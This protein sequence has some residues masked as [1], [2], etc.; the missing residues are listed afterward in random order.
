MN[1]DQANNAITS[2]NSTDVVDGGAGVDTLELTASANNNTQLVGVVKNVEI[3]KIAGSDNINYSLTDADVVA[4]AEA[5]G[6]VA[7]AQ[8]A[9]N[10][11]VAADA[12][13]E[14]ANQAL[15]TAIADETAAAAVNDAVQVIQLVD[16]LNNEEAI[17]AALIAATGAAVLSGSSADNAV[18]QAV[19]N[20]AGQAGAT[21]ATVQAAAQLAYAG[22]A[23]ALANAEEAQQTADAEA[24]A[25]VGALLADLNSAKETLSQLEAA[26]G[27]ASIDASFFQGSTDLILDGK[28]TAVTDVT[29]QTVTFNA[30]A[31]V[32]NSVSYA[33]EVT[34]GKIVLEGVRGTLNL[35]GDDLDT[36]TVEGAV[37]AN[38]KNAG[39]LTLDLADSVKTLNLNL[40]TDAVVKLSGEGELTSITSTGSKNLTLEGLADTVASVTTADGN[41]ELT[42]STALNGNTVK[43]ATV[44]TGAGNDKVAVNVASNT[45]GNKVTVNTG[46]GDDEITVVGRGN[47]ALAISAGAGNDVVNL[48]G[49]TLTTADL[50]DGGEGVDTVVITGKDARTADDY[51]ILNNLLTGFETIKFVSDEG[52]SAALDASKLAARYTTLE[53]AQDGEVVKVGAQQLIAH[54]DLTATAAG[55]VAGVDGTE[56]VYAGTLNIVGQENNWFSDNITAYASAINLTVDASTGNSSYDLRGDVKSAT[57]TLV[58][59]L[60][61]DGDAFVGA[62][63]FELE[64][65]ADEYDDLAELTTLTLSGNG[66]ATV[67]NGD[68]TKL[69]T[70]N[71]SGLNSTNADG[72]IAAGLTY[73]SDNELAETITLGAG[74]DVITLNASTVDATDAIIGFSVVKTAGAFDAAK[75]DSLEI[76]GVNG[77]QLTKF[78]TTQTSLELALLD[79]AR[80]V[81]GVAKDTLAFQFGSDTYVFKD[82]GEAIVGNDV[83]DSNDILVKLVGV[84]VDDAILALHTVA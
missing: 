20:A 72:S 8:V 16:F 44:N 36:A 7:D 66:S 82:V 31:L 5:K 40:T 28:K 73:T 59:K 10:A 54:D 50:I 29:T 64:T 25:D 68:G 48:A 74:Q 80:Y 52:D 42:L 77:A 53:F 79:A 35:N 61:E 33:D 24:A 30:N 9:Y 45:A 17:T 63:S 81:D 70:V 46:A 15:A 3:I 38:G 12:A 43:Q 62:A 2:L 65:F 19:V 78:V 13:L 18:A 4:I 1:Y 22:Y 57:V 71:A 76:F 39:A 37:L 60:N 14:A 55:Y 21:L 58:Q 41:D 32:N 49:Q 27:V 83:V 75:S 56:S 47:A 23:D 26:P 69:V 34:S 84:N 6:E 51:L 11:A 67:I